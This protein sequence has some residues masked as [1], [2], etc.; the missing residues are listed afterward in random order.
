MSVSW[1]LVLIFAVFS[2][3]FSLV[4]CVLSSMCRFKDLTDITECG[5]LWKNIVR[6]GCELKRDVR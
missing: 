5:V 4:S 6:Y 2:I 3:L 1:V